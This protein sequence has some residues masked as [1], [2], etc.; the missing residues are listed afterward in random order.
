MRRSAAFL[1][2]ALAGLPLSARSPLV[3]GKFDL[4]LNGVNKGYEKFK[5]EEKKGERTLSSEIRFQMPMAKAKRNYIDLYLYPVL[6]LDAATGAFRG[7]SYR[8]TFNDFS[9]TDLVE[10]QDSAREVIDQ[11]WRSYDLFNRSAQL[12]QDELANRIDLGVNSGKVY[13]GEKVLHFTQTRFSDSRVKDEPMPEAPFVVDSYT[14]LPYLVLAR[15]A[16][17]MREA[18]RPVTLVFP[19]ALSVRSGSL[20]YMGTDRAPFRG[21]PLILKHFDLFLGTTLL[22]SFWLDRKGEVA[23]VTIPGE[24]LVALRADYTPEPFDQEAPRIVSRNVEVSG[25]FREEKVRVQAPG[26]TLGGT[27]AL[28]QGEG[29]FPAVLLVQDLAAQDRDGNDP[30]DPYSLSGTWKQVAALLAE[31]GVA[32]LRYDSR[33]VGESGGDPQKVSPEDRIGDILALG[34]YLASRPETKGGKVALLGLGLGGWL[35]ARAAAA[36]PAVSAFL[37]VAYPAKPLLR[38]WKEQVGSMT[39]PEARQKAYQELVALEAQAKK[40]AEPEFT[41]RGQRLHME[42]VR[43]LAALDPLDTARA[44]TVPCLFA[45]PERD[46]T[47]QAFHSDILSPALHGGQELL[48]LPGVGHTLAAQDVD[49][50]GTG[51]VDPAAVKTLARWIAAHAAPVGP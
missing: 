34:S 2:L 10:A 4:L 9:K 32:S 23:L 38:L 46:L 29:P 26:V 43:A 12:Q 49:G 36:S 5:I 45:Y 6:T 37:G 31:N 18:S 35:A 21:S 24:G 50:E 20:E 22:S 17:V 16:A 42:A 51:L 28:P 13:P 33:G 3:K 25:G 48:A 44:L 11:D 47:V 39:D 40:G 19:Q 41:F 30:K 1:I 27:L 8:L 15:E 14:F 7:Y